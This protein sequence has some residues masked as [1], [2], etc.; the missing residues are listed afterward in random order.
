MDQPADFV[1]ANFYTSLEII[2]D[3]AFEV[4]FSK[5]LRGRIF[6]GSDRQ[7]KP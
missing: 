2:Q 5:K 7:F 4:S 1:G 6:F 3:S